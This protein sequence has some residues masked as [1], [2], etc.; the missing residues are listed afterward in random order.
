[1]LCSWIVEV[2]LIEKA[3]ISDVTVFPSLL[4]IQCLFSTGAYPMS[5]VAKKPS[6]FDT[7][8]PLDVF[9]RYGMTFGMRPDD[10]ITMFYD[11]LVASEG[12]PKTVMLETYR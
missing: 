11:R 9:A 3:F 1:M 5:F 6:V 7:I 8:R 4:H 10:A 2:F 12:C